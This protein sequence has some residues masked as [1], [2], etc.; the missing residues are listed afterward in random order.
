M[1]T[2]L[3]SYRNKTRTGLGILCRCLNRSGITV[4]LRYALL[5]LL[6]GVLLHATSW[7]EDTDYLSGSKTQVVKNF[8]TDSTFIH[9]VY[10]AE[11]VIA[12]VTFVKAKNPMIFAGVLVL[13]V[14][15]PVLLNVALS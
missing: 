11:V 5:M 8:G 1:K 12:A 14:L 3:L 7:A 4:L 2:L 6:I 15:V 10:F 9:Y 13:L